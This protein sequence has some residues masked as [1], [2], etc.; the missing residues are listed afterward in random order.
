MS[1]EIPTMVSPVVVGRFGFL[2]LGLMTACTVLYTC[3]TDGL[4]FRLELLT[5]H[6]QLSLVLLQ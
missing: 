5:P 6:S 3:I 1:G 4:P 2:A